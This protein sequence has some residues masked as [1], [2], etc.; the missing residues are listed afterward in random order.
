M[1]FRGLDHHVAAVPV[2]THEATGAVG[3]LKT[4]DALTFSEYIACNI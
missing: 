3:G 4:V 1:L 2:Q